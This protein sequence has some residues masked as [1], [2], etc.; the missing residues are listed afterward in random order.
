MSRPLLTVIL[1]VRNGEK[2]LAAAIGSVL[3]QT[4]R[5]FELW[6]L[7]NGSEDGTT[8]IVRSIKDS[9][10]KLFELGPIGVQG[11]LQYAIENTQSDWLA[12]MDADDLMFPERLQTQCDFIK[13]NPGIVFVGTAFGLLTPFGHIFEPMLTSGTREVTKESLAYNRRFFGDPTIVFNRHA[14]VRAGGAD[15]D[16]P[17]VDG[18]PLLFRLLTQGNGWEIAKHLH[19][20]RV[21]PA[22]LSRGNEHLEQAY[23]VRLKYAPEFFASERQTIP[24]QHYWRFIANLELLSKDVKSIR[25]AFHQMK[26]EG[27]WGTKEKVLFLRNLVAQFAFSNYRRR[28]RRRYRY[29]QDWEET[30]RSLLNLDHTSLSITTPEILKATRC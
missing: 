22:S 23:R 5:E 14:A 13:S 2:F 12:R 9:R 8:Q 18:V 28:D 20:Y 15:F 24:E 30:F 10:I 1:P 17:K 4:F 29:R 27:T 16:F 7:E 6:I 21:R 3:N 11:A 19:L 25:R 26:Q